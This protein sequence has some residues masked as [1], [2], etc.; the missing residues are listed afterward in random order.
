MKKYGVDIKWLAV[1]SFEMKFG[2]ITVVSDP[3]ITDCQGTDL[4]YTA[5]EK[6]DIITLSHAHWDHITDIPNLVE[7][8]GCKI[9]CGQ[10]TAMPLA[11]WL[12]Y[13]A[14]RI[15]PMNYGLE[16]DFGDVKVKA[17]F[18]RH[19]IQPLGY[20][21]M[22]AKTEQNPMCKDEGIKELQGVGSLEYV[23]YLFTAKNGTKVL[24]WGCDPT[25]EQIN[26][27]KELKP[28]IAIIQRG[29]SPVQCAEIANLIK[30]MGCKVV[31]PHHHDFREVD[32][33]EV[34]QGFKDAIAKA[35]PDVEFVTLKHGEWMS[36]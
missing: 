24:I 17:L 12:N 10:M 32:P 14:T 18:G 33:P 19:K 29:K 21:D 16:L 7:K 22:T 36:F 25:I 3:Y 2:D 35:T 4:D 11:K 9:L 30:E 34:L 15:Y 8:F 23:N 26:I 28:D 31:I 20:N 5:V 1:T 13:K 27:C 6:C